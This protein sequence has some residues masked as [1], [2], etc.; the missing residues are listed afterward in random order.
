MDSVNDSL[1][2]L[3]L[4]PIYLLCSSFALGSQ[5]FLQLSN[6]RMRLKFVSLIFDFKFGDG[7]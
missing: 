1:R 3:F 2:S 4:P 5:I 6:Y 7:L